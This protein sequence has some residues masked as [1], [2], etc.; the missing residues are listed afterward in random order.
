MKLSALAVLFFFATSALAQLDTIRGDLAF[1]TSK[2]LPIALVNFAVSDSARFRS[3][4][5]LPGKTIARDLLLSGRFTVTELEKYYLLALSR[6]QIRHYVTGRLEMAGENARLTCELRA[7]LTQ[8]YVTGAVYTSPL[9]GV[10]ASAHACVNKVI[11][12]LWGE[13]GIADTRLAWVSRIGG[14]KQVV[15]ADYDGFNRKQV[16]LHQSANFLP[17]WGPQNARVY[18]TSLRNGRTQ[19]FERHLAL[20]ADKLLFPQI[21]QA[22]GPSANPVTGDL[23]IAESN[24]KGGTDIWSGNPA[25]GKAQKLTYWPSIEV[26]PSWSPQG[27][28]F[29]FSSD[30]GGAPQIYSALADG[31]EIERVT[32]FGK[33][34]ESAKWSPDGAKVV[35]ASQESGQ[36]QIYT[37]GIDGSEITQLTNEGSNESP[38]W[39]PDGKMIAFQSNR[40]GPWQ[41][42]LMRSDGTGVTRITTGSEN[43]S[44]AWSHYPPNP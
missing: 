44:P 13:R 5:E 26:S 42:Y 34:N 6:A 2:L 38:T 30:R 35:Y 3:L 22:F 10:R 18:F 23:L 41:I 25:G 20:G 16:T 39:S 33:Y 36:F 31:S 19:I 9:E 11:L 21:D 1:S 28:S 12:Q 15:V 4:E 27:N 32:F 43:T 40:E 8:E 29:V 7:S 37:A 24:P 14:L 17:A